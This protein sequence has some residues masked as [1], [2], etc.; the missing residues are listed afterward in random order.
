MNTPG[1]EGLLPAGIGHGVA[2]WMQAIAPYGIF[3]TDGELRIRNWN[4]WLVTHSGLTEAE[5]LGR[6]I[7]EVFPDLVD[8]RLLVRF[9]RALAGEISVLS[10]A[11][12]RY[13][14]P[15]P[16]TIENAEMPFMLQTARIAPLSEGGEINGTLTIIEDVTLREFQSATLRRQQEMDR[17]L[18]DALGALLQSPD[19]AQ[20]I[21]RIFNPLMP[22]FGLDAYFCYLWNPDSRDFRLHAAVGIAPRQRENLATLAIHADDQPGALNFLQAIKGTLAAHLGLMAGLGLQSRC[23]WPLTIGNRVLG[24]VAF[25]SYAGGPVGFADTNMLSRV[26]H[27]LTIALDRAAKEREAVAASR[28]KDDFLAA[29]SHELRTPL[30]PVLLVASDSANNADFPAA[31][32]MAFRTIEKNALL[33]ARLIDDLL[34]LTRIEHGKLRLELQQV[35]AHVVARDALANVQGDATEKNIGLHLRLNAPRS[36]IQAD[37]ARLQQIFWNVLKNGIKFTPFGGQISISS[38]LEDDARWSMEITDTGIGMDAPELARVFR[39]FS[40]GD[41]AKT[42]GGHQ[43]GG[44][45]LGLA[46]CQKLVELH[47]GRIEA[48]SSGKGLGSTFRIRFDLVTPLVSEPV[49][50]SHAPSRSD[51]P[52]AAGA[53]ARKI[54]LVEDHAPTRAPLVLLLN[55]KG[56]DVIAVGTAA[57]ALAAAARTTFDLVLSDLGLPDMDGFE[58]MR[59]L[60]EKYSMRGIALTGYG[61]ESDVANSTAAGFVAHL[62]KPIHVDVLER[63]LKSTLDLPAAVPTVFTD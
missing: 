27:F 17:L 38:S 35:D 59:A 3:V 43:F 42:S 49:V 1:A 61:M 28:A 48:T 18:S 14:L 37:P 36:L 63:T 8:R 5:V 34:D 6:T 31:A 51:Q 11:L 50:V 15:L 62:T 55:R 7:A 29:L 33:E 24:F 46:I 58:L 47:G 60:R 53:P 2:G 23:S 39:A 16:S 54:L 21:A 44:L 30:N 4:Q 12:H 45:G 26:A 20:D 9:T 57:E 41:H 13:L 25:A 22:S 56:Y 52:I 10:T 19:P 32:R 40:Q